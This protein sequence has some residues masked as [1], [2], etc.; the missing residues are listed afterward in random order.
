MRSSLGANAEREEALGCSDQSRARP[1]RIR[2][3]AKDVFDHGSAFPNGAHMPEALHKAT[4]LIL[5]G[6]LSRLGGL[7]TVGDVEAAAYLRPTCLFRGDL[8]DEYME[9]SLSSDLRARGR[10][11]SRRATW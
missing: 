4:V 1:R 8:A 3:R 2:E 11:F 5:D 7:A 9:T 6:T 10:G